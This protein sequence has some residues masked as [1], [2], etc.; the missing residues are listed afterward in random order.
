MTSAMDVPS[1]LDAVT[2]YRREA[3]CVRRARLAG[4]GV[5]RVRFAGLP[6]ALDAGSLR[7]WVVEGPAGLRVLDVQAG[8]DVVLGEEVDVPAESQA[9]EAA[10][11]EA[12]RLGAA[13]GRL[14]AEV[15]EIENLR[16]KLPDLKRN[17][18][19]R[20][21]P[22]AAMLALT[23][24]VDARLAALHARRR[25]LRKAL[26]AAQEAVTLR[27]QR[28][29]E[30]SSAL[31]SARTRIQRTAVATLSEAPSGPVEL[32]LEYVVRGVR[33]APSYELRLAPGLGAGVLAMRAA[34]AQ[35][36][37]ED[38]NGVAL[39]LSTASLSR[40]AEVPVGKALKI[41]RAQPAPPRSGFR[42]PPPGLDELFEPYDRAWA[43]AG[44][45]GAAGDR[46]SFRPAA[47][48][49]ARAAAAAKPR[50]SRP[51]KGGMRAR[52]AAVLED[53]D[54]AFDDVPA[55]E[56]A[57]SPMFAG[58]APPAA[59]PS[60]SPVMA[61]MAPPA[62]R[63]MER[64]A[65]GG[66]LPGAG[67]D[68]EAEAASA[69]EEPPPEPAPEPAF[70]PETALLDYQR[71]VMG[72]PDAG[73]GR[74][75]LRPVTQIEGGAGAH[76]QVNLRVDVDVS[77]LVGVVAHARDGA[78]QVAALP[79]PARC[80]EAA[81][82]DHFDYRYDCAHR[83]D[84]PSTGAWD[85]VPVMTCAVGLRPGYVTVPAVEP[86]VFRTLE[87][88]NT[89]GHALLPGP[90]DVSVGDELLLTSTLPGLPPGAEGL[91]LGLGV[92]EAIK[93][94]RR[95]RFREQ[96]GGLLGGK[97]VLVH[98][99]EV[100]LNNRLGTP[101]AIEVRERVPVPE[102]GQKDIEVEETPGKPAWQKEEL[103]LDGEGAPVPGLRRWRL[104]LAPGERV[105][106]VGRY[107]VRI[108]SDKMLVGGNRRS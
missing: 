15:V 75:R 88:S 26:E 20:A 101:A 5:Q 48:T 69:N 8:F 61:T 43:Q 86:Q 97:S 73:A 70:R 58:S 59:P 60:P 67:G 29:A 27:Q 10:E 51:A 17:E 13:L 46:P 16:P 99:L 72:A 7:G 106:L 30:A 52:K 82:L 102:A 22:V 74:G 93:V 18:T 78:Q 71:L 36:T 84:V 2:I 35:A 89:S 90:V 56:L 85:T 91:R 53:E 50:P 24:L 65:V 40:S 104:T 47:S 77:V 23:D 4:A 6:L 38:W 11:E 28:L 83:V 33:W 1:V 9:L 63:M 39:S 44:G 95:T 31:S 79:L 37:G 21:A 3:V 87:L 32:A 98:E 107:A 64:S 49:G 76:V 105:T 96:S 57:A 81:P 66:M 54:A 100:E 14:D 62:M 68:D 108:P 103:P 12:E 80:Q 45:A 19:P 34:V 41:G 92:E 94:A 25:G 55:A 42:E